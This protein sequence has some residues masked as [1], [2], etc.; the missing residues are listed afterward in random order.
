[1]PLE[2]SIVRVRRSGILRLIEPSSSS[3]GDNRRLVG[4][5][6]VAVTCLLMALMSSIKWWSVI[7]TLLGS[8]S[9]FWGM[10]DFRS[11]YA[12]G[13]LVA[14]GHAPDLY[15]L[16]VLRGEGHPTAEPYFNPPFFALFLAPLSLLPI[17]HAYRAWTIITLVLLT[18]NVGMLWR[19]TA[20]LDRR[21]RTLIVCALV[22]SAPSV[23]GLILGQFSQILLAS[24][25]A[26][27]LFL[28]AGRPALAGAALIPLLIKPELVI[29]VTLFLA[30]KRQ[31]MA[32]VTL[33]AGA[34]ALVA[35]SFVMVGIET[36]F[37]YPVYVLREAELQITSWMFGWNGAIG[38]LFRDAPHHFVTTVALVLTVLTFGC[39]AYA[40]RGSFDPTSE[41][42]PR[43][44]IALTLATV[45][46]D[47]HLFMQ[48]LLILAPALTAYGVGLT[49]R[50]RVRL[51]GFAAGLW[52]VL[53]AT[54]LLN[55]PYNANILV[56]LA[57]VG[58]L[59]ITM[60]TPAAPSLRRKSDDTDGFARAA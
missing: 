29:G 28:R 50:A 27:F 31:T 9:H 21:W 54:P 46:S 60:R 4:W 24:W 45:L 1:M 14:E 39:A 3:G 53:G 23:N 8:S 6:A 56:A 37:H 20:P 35:L 51:G 10:Y 57:S 30:W 42:F 16:D 17:H 25:S 58:L 11:F 43:L 15:T 26:S 40:W 22:T 49:G 5:C 52:I 59:G 34:T 44:W 55:W 41:A 36:G 7:A 18:I 32:V 12:A 13:A 33:S 2:E 19:I 48:D 38:A 47:L